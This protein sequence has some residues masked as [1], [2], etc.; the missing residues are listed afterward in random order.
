MAPRLQIGDGVLLRARGEEEDMQ[1]HLK[2]YLSDIK[3]DDT[4]LKMSGVLL[5]NA[6]LL[7]LA[8]QAYLQGQRNQQESFFLEL[9]DLYEIWGKK[10][11]MF[12]SYLD[13]L[14]V[15]G[16][17][18]REEILEEVQGRRMDRI[19]EPEDD[20]LREG[21]VYQY[22]QKNPNKIAYSQMLVW[23]Y[24]Q[25]KEF[26]KAFVQAKAID[27][28]L[29]AE[30]R[31]IME[32][33]NLSFNNEA[34]DDAVKI[35]GYLAKEYPNSGFVYMHAKNVLIKA[36][37]EVVKR[38]YPIDINAIRSLVADYEESIEE[39]GIR[40]NTVEA[41]RDMA[42]LYAFYLSN[43]DTAV[44]ILQKLLGQPRISRRQIDEAK[45]N[46]GD[47]YILKE[48]PWE[49]ALLYSKVEKSQKD[50]LLDH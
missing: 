47:I 19:T 50:K 23:L 24:L 27:R 14:A 42:K 6:G 45:L 29:K 4:R 16:D 9:A 28:R 12:Q 21:L 44:A 26:Y 32:I 5:I 38:T 10:E 11:E 13:M 48:E 17:Q 36:K 8:E 22:L 37:E 3:R 49:S 46:L 20:R 30:G 7:E 15:T 40:S 31:E 25:R 34:F 41:V 43:P 2:A 35:Y 18:Y 33:A 39:F 1:E